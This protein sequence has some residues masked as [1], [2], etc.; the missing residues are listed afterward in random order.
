MTRRSLQVC[1]PGRARRRLQQARADS[2]RPSTG[3]PFP[4]NQIPASFFSPI[5]KYYLQ[6]LPIPDSTGST[7]AGANQITN[8]N[9][10]TARLDYL[11]NAKQTLNFTI[12]R[13]DST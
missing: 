6:F 12:N 2:D 7:V 10:I 8:N 13:F 4:G 3:R 1:P 11:L 5:A 9:Y